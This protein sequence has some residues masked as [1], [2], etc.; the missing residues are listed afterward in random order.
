ML[1]GEYLT[2]AVDSASPQHFE[3]IQDAIRLSNRVDVAAHQLFPAPPLLGDETCPLEHGHVLL[4]RGEA[5]RVGAG[6][7]RDGVLSTQR[8]SD[9][10]PSGTVGERSEDPVGSLLVVQF[11]NHMVVR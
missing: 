6:Q 4:N 7:G 3:L 5:H 2:E 9:D 8:S 11:Y 1:L 10:V